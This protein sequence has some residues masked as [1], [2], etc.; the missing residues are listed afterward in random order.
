MR[1]RDFVRTCALSSVACACEG[2]AARGGAPLLGPFL[3]DP[4]PDAMGFFLEATS[5]EE[6]V[7]EVRSAGDGPLIAEAAFPLDAWGLGRADVEGLS[8][9]AEY[10][11]RLRVGRSPVFEGHFHTLPRGRATR[12][13]L[14]LGADIHWAFKPYVVFD[15]I[16]ERAPD[17]MLAAGDNVYADRAPFGVVDAAEADYRAVYPLHWEDDALG[18]CW[19]EVPAMLMWDDHEILDDYDGADSVRFAAAAAAFDAYQ[20]LRNP[21]PPRLDA[22]HFGASLGPVDLF[23]LDT[24]S[25]RH[26][27]DATDGPGKSMLGVEQLSDLRRH[28]LGSD[29]PLK[30]IVSPTTFHGYGAG[31]NDGW[32][33]GFRHERDELFGFIRDEDIRGVVLVSGDKHWPAVLR[34]EIGGGRELI[35]L[36][37]TPLAAFGRPSPEEVGPDVLFLGPPE[38]GFGFLE[39][40]GTGN[41]FGA[42]FAWVD[43][44]GAEL[45]TMELAVS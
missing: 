14:A 9:D 16:R 2:G 31:G 34:H 7:V 44:R 39:A 11:Y 30:L 15:R 40:D 12:V 43:A 38:V 37:C 19:S 41:D 20:G 29:A 35:E 33:D 24:R 10:G 42:R 21:P 27:N 23:V 1:R 3:C 26:P 4:R 13:S 36:Q 28:L 22:R 5:R 25:H 8:P 18:R 6:H 45:F 17:V 32:G